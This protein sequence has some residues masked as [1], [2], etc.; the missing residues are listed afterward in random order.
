M[1]PVVPKFIDEL[2]D[3]STEAKKKD[4]GTTLKAIGQESGLEPPQEDPRIQPGQEKSLK[5][6]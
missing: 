2:I 3:F 5:R 6:H 4:K 1:E